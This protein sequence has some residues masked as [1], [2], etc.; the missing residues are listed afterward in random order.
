MD[1]VGNVNHTLSVVGKWIFGSNYETSLP[2]NIG[3]LNLICGCCDEDYYFE[4]S[5]VCIV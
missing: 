1:S 3:I 4:K 2:L 5:K